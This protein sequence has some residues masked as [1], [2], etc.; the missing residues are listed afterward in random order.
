M[1][2][3]RVGGATREH[4]GALGAGKRVSSIARWT[5]IFLFFYSLAGLTSLGGSDR[6]IVRLLTRGIGD[7]ISGDAQHRPFLYAA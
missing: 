4:G 3:G 5:F 1:L 7:L 6:E 2:R